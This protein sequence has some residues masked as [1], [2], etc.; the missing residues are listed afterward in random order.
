M[1]RLVF[2]M[3]PLSYWGV[4]IYLIDSFSCGRPF[5][6][7]SKRPCPYYGRYTSLWDR[8]GGSCWR[9]FNAGVWNLLCLALT[10]IVLPNDSCYMMESF[11]L[12]SYRPYTRLVSFLFSFTVLMAPG[13]RY[14]TNLESLQKNGELLVF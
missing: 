4:Y 11:P 6:K 10:F 1:R 2:C 3:R 5:T 7:L 14:L 9:R 12:L 8:T 13:F